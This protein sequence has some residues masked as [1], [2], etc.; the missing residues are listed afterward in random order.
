MYSVFL[1]SLHSLTFSADFLYWN[2]DRIFSSSLLILQTTLLRFFYHKNISIVNFHTCHLNCILYQWLESTSCFFFRYSTWSI[3]LFGFIILFL[4]IILFFWTIFCGNIVKIR[5]TFLKMNYKLK[6]STIISFL[7][8]IIY[9]NLESLIKLVFI[10]TMYETSIKLV[11]SEPYSD[12]ADGA[13]SQEMTKIIP[14]EKSSRKL[15]Y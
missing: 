9:Y 15:L 10:H 7:K 2:E 1:F 13:Y 11:Y 8:I 14:W 3:H 12:L 4:F 6:D 5:G